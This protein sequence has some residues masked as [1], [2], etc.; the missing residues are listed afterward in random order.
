MLNR[1][2]VSTLLKAVILSTALVVVIGF[3]ISAWSSW[4]RLQQANRIVAVSAASAEVFKAMANIRADRSTSNRQLTSD[5]A[6]DK[7]IEKYIRDIREALMPALARTL[8]ILP[9]TDLAQRDTLLADLGALNK[10]LLAEQAEFWTEVLKPRAERRAALAKEYVATEDTLMA[11]LEKL[12]SALAASVNHQDAMIDQ[13]LTVKQMA[14]LLRST[15]GESSQIVGNALGSGK[16]TPELQLAYTKFVGGTDAAWTAI[17]LAAS[18]MQL[19][20]ALASA[21]SETKSTYF[22][23]Q[24]AATR[25]GVITAFAKGEK[26]TMTANQWS[27]Y[28]V[29]RMMT[30]VKLADAALQAA[31]DHSAE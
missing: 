31:K 6:M 9:T 1:L 15:A 30:A 8:E 21:I 17:E 23:P 22:D 20:P 5:V 10:T 3:S 16:I 25:D 28:S 7:D 19:P 2:T 18:G 11:Q 27:P 4:G 24:Y 13:L 29:P 12:S 26:P 14:W